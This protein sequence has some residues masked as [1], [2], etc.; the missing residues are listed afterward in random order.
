MMCA[1]RSPH[2]RSCSG[3]LLPLLAAPNHV[4]RRATSEFRSPI[5]AGRW[6]GGVLGMDESNLREPVPHINS[7]STRRLGRGQTRMAERNPSREQIAEFSQRHG[8]PPRIAKLILRINS[9]SRKRCDEAA[10]TYLKAEAERLI[11]RTS[12]AS[13]VR[14]SD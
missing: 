11:R 13:Q 3:R 6:T 4:D 7:Y 12:R 8:L 2:C 14:S 9:P 10:A 1:N 5:P